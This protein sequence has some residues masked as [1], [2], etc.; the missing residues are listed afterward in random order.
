MEIKKG[1]KLEAMETG[2]FQAP[3]I[4]FDKVDYLSSYEKLTYL[5]LCRC[6]NNGKVGFPSYSTIAANCSFSRDTAIRAVRSLFDKGCITKQKGLK[7]ESNLYIVNYKL[8]T[9]SSRQQPSKLEVVADSNQVVADSNQQVV[10]G[11]NPIKNYVLDKDIREK[12][13]LPIQEVKKILNN[14]IQGLKNT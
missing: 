4:L 5:Y 11:S 10:A 8:L 14:L 1:D 13:S 6:C 9:G 2:Y 7:G 12:E 3:N